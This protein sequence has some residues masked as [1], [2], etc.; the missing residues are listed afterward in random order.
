M[1]HGGNSACLGLFTSYTYTFE[2][3][4]RS[5]LVR[6]LN[7][8]GIGHI[9]NRDRAHREKAKRNQVKKNRGYNTMLLCIDQVLTP[10]E[11]EQTMSKLADAK[12][13]DGKSTAGWHAQ[14]VKNNLQLPTDSPIAQELQN[15]VFQALLRNP[16]FQMAVRP[17]MVRPILFSRYEP[18][19]SYGFHV[20]NALMGDRTPNRSDV[21]LTLFLSSPSDYE[22]GELVMDTLFGERSF[23]LNAG[24]MVVY[25]SSTLHQVKPITKGIRFAAI[26]WIQSLVRDPADREILFDLDTVRQL[27]YNKYGKTPEFDLLSKSHANLLRKWADV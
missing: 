1:Q 9:A 21:S 11:L 24:S 8:T 20:D 26:T 7:Q 13:V 15:L 4:Y 10:Q 22:G 12:F 19:M 18:G 2:P 5:Y 17:K 27:M 6:F 14:Q 16:L 3:R 23:K 25:P